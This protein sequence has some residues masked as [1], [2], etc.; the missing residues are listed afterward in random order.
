MPPA[1][2]EFLEFYQMTKNRVDWQEEFIHEDFWKYLSGELKPEEPCPDVYRFRVV[3]DRFCDDLVN[4]VENYGQ[5][6]TG[7]NE[8]T[9]LQ[10]GYENMPTRVIHM[11]Q[12]GLHDEWLYFMSNYVQLLQKKVFQYYESDV[13]RDFSKKL[14]QTYI[15]CTLFQPP[16]AVMQFVV[17]YRPDEQL[18]LRSYNDALTY[19][20]SIALNSY[21]TDFQGGGVQFLRYNCSI[22]DTKKGYLIMHPGQLTHY[23]EGLN[24]TNGTRYVAVTYV[25]P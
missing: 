10:G 22:T 12:V 7:T 3:T 21:G 14:N 8:D 23:Y 11:N 15:M 9:R 20:F 13:C 4:I 18:N 2:V 25:D 5:W 6:S 16:K 17:R 1:P 24:T 19:M